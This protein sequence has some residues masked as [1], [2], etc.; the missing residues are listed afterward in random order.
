MKF[1]PPGLVLLAIPL[2]A[3][4]LRHV[5]VLRDDTQYYITPWLTRLRN[6]ELV[7]TAREAHVRASAQR[8]HVDP[9]ARGVLVRSKD[10]GETWSG[11]IV[12]DDETHRFS[13][14]QDVPFTQLRDGSLLVTMYSWAVSPLPYR[15]PDPKRAFTYTFEGLW[16]LSSRDDGATWTERRPVTVKGLPP[17]STRVPPVQ[18]PD[19]TLVMAVYDEGPKRSGLD[20]S[21]C[22]AI[23]SNDGGLT[24]HSPALIAE[25]ENHRR[26][27][28]EPSLVRL[29]SGK[30]LTMIRITSGRSP[31]FPDSKEGFLWQ[32]ESSD[33]GRTWSKPVKTA[34]W[35]Y[36][37]DVI[38]LRD[39]R[40]LCTYGYRQKPYG[41]RVVLS[42]D[43]GKTWDV[44]HAIV[45]R[46]DGGTSDLGYP[47]SVELPDGRVLTV[48]W[49]NHEKPGDERSAT[50][51]VAGT[52]Y[53]P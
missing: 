33:D 11:K 20:W 14:T 19:G 8:G 44:D 32:S 41:V 34:V 24:W 37:A 22:W 27:F 7:V 38:E 4:D 26:N 21:R 13:Q 15:F 45:L 43:G 9:T 35:G 10:G 6:G 17:L 29:R 50:R 47:S 36:P 16:S 42:R 18:L 2:L 52:F 51:Y 39:G 3:A 53:R 25:D 23:R 1:A 40:L 5:V 28:E 30:L 12:F 46:E 49:I 31:L 48:Y